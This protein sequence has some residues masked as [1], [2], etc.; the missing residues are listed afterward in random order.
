M[1]RKKRIVYIKKCQKFPV[2]RAETNQCPISYV[3]YITAGGLCTKSGSVFWWLFFIKIWFFIKH[4]KVI[5]QRKQNCLIPYVMS[6]REKIRKPSHIVV[7][8]MDELG[9]HWDMKLWKNSV[10]LNLS[11]WYHS[12]LTAV[13]YHIHAKVQYIT[14]LKLNII[15]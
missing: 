7:L 3:C 6:I 11:F 13:V 4:E 2:W 8:I 5:W 14:L 12:L 1:E 10:K 15:N 9:I